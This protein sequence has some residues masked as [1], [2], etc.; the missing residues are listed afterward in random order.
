MA[1]VDNMGLC[2]H[3]TNHIQASVHDSTLYNETFDGSLIPKNMYCIGDG[4]F[5][6]C[7]RIICNYP[8][9]CTLS[10]CEGRT[11]VSNREEEI[12]FVIG[13]N[14]YEGKGGFYGV[15][16]EYKYIYKMKGYFEGTVSIL[17][18]KSKTEHLKIEG[19]G[20]VEKINKNGCII[21]HMDNFK[22]KYPIESFGNN[23]LNIYCNCDGFPAQTKYLKSYNIALSSIRIG[24][25]NLFGRQNLLWSASSCTYKWSLDIYDLTTKATFAAT[26]YHAFL[27]PIRKF[28]FQLFAFTNNNSLGLKLEEIA[29]LKIPKECLK[30]I[31][32]ETDEELI[33]KAKN[34]GNY[35]DLKRR[36]QGMITESSL[37]VKVPK[38]ISISNSDFKD[39]NAASEKARINN[40][41]KISLEGAIGEIENEC[42]VTIQLNQIYNYYGIDDDQ[43]LAMKQQLESER[44]DDKMIEEIDD[45]NDSIIISNEKSD[46]KHSLNQVEFDQKNFFECS[47]T[48]KVTKFNDLKEINQSEKIISNPE[49]ISLQTPISMNKSDKFNKSNSINEMKESIQLNQNH[50]TIQSI[51]NNQ[52]NQMNTNYININYSNEI[53]Q[54]KENYNESQSSECELVSIIQRNKCKLI[55]NFNRITMKE[56]EN[57]DHMTFTTS[58]SLTIEKL[59]RRL[60]SNLLLLY[61][62]EN[63][64]ISEKYYLITDSWFAILENIDYIYFDENISNVDMKKREEYIKERTKDFGKYIGQS[65]KFIFMCCHGRTH[66]TLC[67]L[68]VSL[69]KLIVIDSLN[70]KNIHN[71]LRNFLNIIKI[72]ENPIE[73]EELNIG[74]QTDGW[75]CGYYM[76]YYFNELFSNKKEFQDYESLNTFNQ[77]KFNKLLETMEIYFNKLKSIVWFQNQHKNDE[78]PIYINMFSL[79]QC[80]VE[81]IYDYLISSKHTFDDKGYLN[82]LK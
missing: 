55:T 5:R 4:G 26:N 61:L 37:E 23:R 73:V 33:D 63:L 32:F 48:R 44:N 38:Q 19:E 79:N 45:V 77:E 34:I 65:E 1:F 72:C 27:N 18:D 57:D 64:N 35:F 28:P 76:I 70:F 7:A 31:G 54:L 59:H 53:D 39:S 71:H 13:P 20:E 10:S 36:K 49:M 52:I 41:S 3:V 40:I 30:I 60:D 80:T 15:V 81:M 66:W 25:E 29:K 6:G 69:S 67:I 58:D 74:I 46:N 17:N 56:N 42:F 2:V 24:I 75:K 82:C 43:I 47:I 22:S 16:T 12:K 78:N 50:Q 11:F 68:E 21:F 8:K 62:K 51:Q 9:N 14:H